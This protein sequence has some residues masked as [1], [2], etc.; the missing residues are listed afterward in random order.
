MFLV[1]DT[2]HFLVALRRQVRLTPT[3][4]EAVATTMRATGRPIIVTSIVLAAGFSILCLGNFTP[5][6]SF[7]MVSAVV[8]LTA[9][10]ADLVMLPAALIVIRPR[11]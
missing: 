1:D 3:I 9:L 7:G 5:N 8:I 2:V 4:D 10:V 6:I 11:L